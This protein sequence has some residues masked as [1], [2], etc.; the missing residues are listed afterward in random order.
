MMYT[1]IAV[2]AYIFMRSLEVVFADHRDR[3]WYKTAIRIVAVAVMYVAAAAMV[4][5]YFENLPLLGI[6]PG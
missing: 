6:K 4:T 1:F 3:R 2:S 5:F